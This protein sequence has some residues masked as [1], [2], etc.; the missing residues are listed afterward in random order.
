MGR[1]QRWKDRSA[2]T[3][4][5]RAIQEQF[6]PRLQAAVQALQMAPD[7]PEATNDTSAAVA[8]KLAALEAI[9]VDLRALIPGPAIPL[10]D[11]APSLCALPA[12]A[13]LPAPDSRSAT[14]L[15]SLRAWYCAWIRL[16]NGVVSMARFPAARI[17]PGRAKNHRQLV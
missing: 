8:P 17:F 14:P 1:V 5:E 12:D 15:Q 10:A 2:E 9:A 3:R 16:V 4:H 6:G 7:A 13:D 11:F